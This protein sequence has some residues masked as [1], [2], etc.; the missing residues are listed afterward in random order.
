MNNL[1]ILNG[2][3][4]SI[5]YEKNIQKNSM[6]SNKDNNNTNAFS[7]IIELIKD[8]DAINSSSEY[9]V[10]KLEGG[11]S[12]LYR[13]SKETKFAILIVFDKNIIK[14]NSMIE[15]SKVYLSGI[16]KNYNNK[17]LAN[18]SKNNFHLFKTKEMVMTAIE[19]LTVKY[20]ENLRKNKLYSK[21]IYYN[22]NPNVISSI[23]YK[24]SKLESTSVILYNSNKDYDKMYFSFINII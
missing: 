12:V 21:F 20:I 5:I 13:K 15:M 7:S 19:D 9:Y 8:L 2:E 11:K 14:R 16:E 3:N 22:Y 10:M 1:L 24:K 17:E 18:A 4:Y 6:Y 23:S